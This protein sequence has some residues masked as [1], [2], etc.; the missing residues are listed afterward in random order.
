MRMEAA[1]VSRER[2]Q[3]SLKTPAHA[4]LSSADDKNADASPGFGRFGEFHIE[5]QS[6]RLPV[7]DVIPQ[8]PDPKL[9]FGHREGSAILLDFDALIQFSRYQLGEWRVVPRSP[10]AK[11]GRR[12]CTRVRG[13]LL[14]RNNSRLRAGISSS[15]STAVKWTPP[16]GGLRSGRSILINMFSHSGSPAMPRFTTLFARRGRPRT[17]VALPL[18]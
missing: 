17:Q 9:T 8:A 1:P 13:T 3:R 15:L 5:A 7:N 2:Q 10:P 6:S 14:R 4:H 11:P 16:A 12:G 18:S